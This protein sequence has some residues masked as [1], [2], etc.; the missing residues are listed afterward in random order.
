MPTRE[1]MKRV[2][3]NYC[4]GRLCSRCV[5][6]NDPSHVLGKCSNPAVPLSVL[7]HNYNLVIEENEINAQ[8]EKGKENNSKKGNDIMVNDI[9]TNDERKYLLNNMKKL[10]SEYDYRYKEDALET[11]IRTWALNKADLIAAFKKHPN[12]VEGKFM[13]AFDQDYV[14]D[15]DTI[16]VKEFSNFIQ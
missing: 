10:L 5:I 6:F 15:I 4:R 16:A 2:I 12:Y 11:I 14:R 3:D 7:V 9:I 1:E 13:I 8:K